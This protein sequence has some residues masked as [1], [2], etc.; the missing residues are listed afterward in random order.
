[1]NV[2][3]TLIDGERA[4]QLLEDETLTAIFEKVK[5]HYLDGWQATLPDDVE[6]R[7]RLYIAIQVL[8]HVRAHIRVVAEAGQLAKA[9]VERLKTRRGIQ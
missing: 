6:G 7:E 5:E 3:Q 1:M 9:Q 4:R 8:E 2:H